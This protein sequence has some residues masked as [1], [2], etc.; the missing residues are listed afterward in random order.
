[1]LDSNTY[2]CVSR[3]LQRNFSIHLFNIIQYVDYE[4][5]MPI[6]VQLKKK[7]EQNGENILFICLFTTTRFVQPGAKR[8]QETGPRNKST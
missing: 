8:C 6:T 4:P 2:P 1:M 3:Q 5:K 7:G